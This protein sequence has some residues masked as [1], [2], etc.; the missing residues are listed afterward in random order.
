MSDEE[1]ERLITAF[2]DLGVSR[3][4]I[5]G[6]EP[7]VRKDL[8]S[9]IRRLDRIAGIQDLS[10]STNAVL[11]GDSAGLLKDAG[12]RR[13]N[14]S[15]DTLDPDKFT[16][17][18]GGRLA[19][20]LAGLMAAKAA[21][22]SPVKINV[23]AL[24][25]IN[26]DEFVNIAHFCLEHGFTLR[27]IEA[28]PVGKGGSRASEHYLDLRRVKDNLAGHF[29]LVPSVM[30][31]G[32]PARYVKVRN[33]PLHIGF[34]TPISR[35]FCASCNRI[36]LSADGIIYPCLG[37]DHQYPLRSLLRTGSSDTALKNAILHAV[38]HK[39][40]KHEFREKPWQ[41]IRF[42]SATGG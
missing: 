30:P 24:R 40:L 9:L 7:L 23:L 3:V 41:V 29:D 21:G 36:R 10:L 19:P 33:S 35:H 31:G 4:R 26:D 28:M 14:V 34:I 18:T 32:G 25:G 38:K 11:L 27:F 16:R 20:V 13:I 37:Q 17:L 12:I 2:A 22:L 8:P 15:L 5:T 1:I 6:G 39:P 42:M